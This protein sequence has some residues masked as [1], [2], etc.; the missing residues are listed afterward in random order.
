[1]S[2]RICLITGA[3]SGIG[4]AVA[5]ELAKK[6]YELI[7]IGRNLK[8][9]ENVVREITGRNNNTT[10]KYYVADISLIKEVKKTM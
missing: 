4:K 8:K 1:M 10:V 2:K 7:L 9:C 6:N 5:F 3:T